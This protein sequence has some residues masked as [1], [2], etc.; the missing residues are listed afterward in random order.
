MILKFFGCKSITF[1]S[2]GLKQMQLDTLGLK[3]ASNGS[4]LHIIN[5]LSCAKYI[6]CVIIFRIVGEDDGGVLMTPQQYEKYKKKVIPQRMKNRLYTTW[7]AP[8]GMDCKCVGP[9]TLCFCNHR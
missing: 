1:I 4:W 3:S 5:Y 9:E 2:L 8:N 6:K 7:V